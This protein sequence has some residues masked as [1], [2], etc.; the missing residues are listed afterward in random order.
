MGRSSS[1]RPIS[2]CRLSQIS[3][4]PT[5]GEAATRADGMSPTMT[6]KRA[7]W[8]PALPV[9][10]FFWVFLARPGFCSFA[11]RGRTRSCRASMRASRR[12][13]CRVCRG[14][15]R[16]WT[17]AR[18]CAHRTH[19]LRGATVFDV[20]RD[21]ANTTLSR[22]ANRLHVPTREST[23]ENQLL[24]QAGDV[25]RASQLAES[26]RILRDTRY[27]R[28]A[29]IRPIAYH[30][31]VV[32]VEVTTQEVW[33]FSP[34]VSFGRKGGKNTGGIEV[35][36]LNF[37]GLGTQLGIGLGRASIA[38]RRPSTTAT[39]SLA[40]RGGTSR[41]VT[42]TTAM[43]DSR[44]FPS[45]IPSMRSTRAGPPA[46]NCW[47]TS[48]SI[49]ATTSARSSTSSRPTRSSRTIYWGHSDGLVGG[50]ARRLSFGLTTEE[51]HVRRGA[52]CAAD[53]ADAR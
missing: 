9:S 49:R 41:R 1:R 29:L 17:R 38:T 13:I 2:G 26:A 24:F 11:C 27:L 30:D 5:A 18:G 45:T 31:G 36:D 14:F 3:A 6:S 44:R 35:E 20:E 37:L 42:R 12:P 19:S 25:Y 16:T 39:G 53:L 33:T 48:A 28:D 21:D 32:D 23:I 15:P 40:P 4:F 52:R 50:W 46:S 10:V 8:I 22:L 43:A 51:S 34:G 47:T 7:W